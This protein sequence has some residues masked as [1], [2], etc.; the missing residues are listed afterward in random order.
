ME[1]FVLFSVILFIFILLGLKPSAR[2][3]VDLAEGNSNSTVPRC[4][5][6][7][8]IP[9]AL[10]I[11]DVINLL[12]RSLSVAVEIDVE[13]MRLL[14]VALLLRIIGVV[15]WVLMLARLG[16]TKRLEL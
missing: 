9:A 16:V 5:C 8:S 14:L 6:Y 13:G 12:K 1:K 4:T 11:P 10:L 7:R 15:L 3:G 2:L